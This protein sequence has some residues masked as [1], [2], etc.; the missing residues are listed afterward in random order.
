ML[1]IFLMLC[2]S[3]YSLIFATF[4]FQTVCFGCIVYFLSL[5]LFERAL[6]S[7]NISTFDS[8]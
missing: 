5:P 8:G 4:Q 3:V 2:V 7:P 1:L 6:A